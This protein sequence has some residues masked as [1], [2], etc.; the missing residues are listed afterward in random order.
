MTIAKAPARS[1]NH[2]TAPNPCDSDANEWGSETIDG[3]YSSL[4]ADETVTGFG[5][6]DTDLLPFASYHSLHQ[7]HLSE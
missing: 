2:D 1:R 4:Y 7:Y 6:D 5:N 3:S